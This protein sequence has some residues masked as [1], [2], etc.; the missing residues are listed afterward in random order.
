MNAAS[1]GTLV[2]YIAGVSVATE[3]VVELMKGYPS[4]RG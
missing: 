2:G 1:L 3:R 4:F